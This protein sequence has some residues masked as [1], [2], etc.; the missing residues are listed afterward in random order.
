MQA[1]ELLA[2]RGRLGTASGVAPQGECRVGRRDATWQV[3]QP[4]GGLLTA[5]MRRTGSTAQVGSLA[6]MP[7]Q[8][9]WFCGVLLKSTTLRRSPGARGA[10]VHFRRSPTI[11]KHRQFSA[12]PEPLA[13]HPLPARSNPCAHQ[14]NSMA[15]LVRAAS[16][17]RSNSHLTE[18]S[19]IRS[20][21]RSH[22]RRGQGQGEHAVAARAWLVCRW[23]CRLK[24]RLRWGCAPQGGCRRPLR[25]V[26][27][28]G[29][30]GDV[31]LR[32]GSPT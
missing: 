22:L 31:A 11:H 12:P 2:G 29:G 15:L 10:G 13:Q 27:R 28:P 14:S 18:S 30:C 17:A 16:P 3:T 26:S 20:V 21:S 1:V 9:H 6:A 24:A 23:R 25:C 32:R 5:R 19:P 7:A 8:S 4:R